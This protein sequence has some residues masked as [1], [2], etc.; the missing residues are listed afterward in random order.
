MIQFDEEIKKYKPCLEIEEAEEAIY[1][2][3]TKDIVDIIS[4]LLKEKDKK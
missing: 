1:S 2:Y 4:E 3:D